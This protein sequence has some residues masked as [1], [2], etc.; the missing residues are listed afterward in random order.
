MNRL[1]VVAAA[2]VLSVIAGHAG[3]AERPAAAPTP[4]N[5]DEVFQRLGAEFVAADRSDG[6][7]IAVVENGQARFYNYGTVSRQKP[8]APTEHTVYEI[9]SITKILTS[10]I[11]ANA[12]GEGKVGLQDDI[13]RYLPG[14]YPK[15]AFDGEPVRLIHLANTSSAL[16]D[17]LPALPADAEQAP[18]QAV[19]ALKRITDQHVY[20]ALASASPSD[21][22][23]HEPRHSNLAANLMGGILERVYGQP[24]EALLARY[25]EQ[26]LGMAAGTGEARAALLATGYNRDR[27]A[28]PAL[29]ARSVLAGGGLRYST[30]DLAKFLGAQL[31]A[32]DAAIRLSQTPAWGDADNVA[33]GFNWIISKTIDDQLHLRHSG[34]TFGFSSYIEMYPQRGYGIVLLANRPGEAQGQLQELANRATEALWGKPPVLT[35][36]ESALQASAYRDVAGTVAQVRREHRAL[37]LTEDYLNQWGYRLLADKQTAQAVALFGYA[38]QQW[39][40]SWNAFDSLGEAYELAGDRDRAI[41]NYQR[42]LDLSPSNGNA[43][44]HLRKLR[45]QP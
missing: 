19:A 29:D 11:L 18:F 2:W 38:A 25:V 40:D 4:T 37:H 22:P 17:N 42:S 9:G 15:L 36:L 5:A 44:E 43:A 13:R 10:L 3:A 1:A 32:K 27:A 7:S 23:G 14:E 33:V 35:A 12:V 31:S 30:A 39:P 28:M 24:Y 20:T 6:L 45:Q 21:R 34:G 8:Q 16:P 41:A 26:P